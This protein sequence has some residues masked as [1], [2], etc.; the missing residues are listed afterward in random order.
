MPVRR[1]HPQRPAVIPAS[2]PHTSL[3]G[4]SVQR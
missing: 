2:V 1:Y 4:R 3:A